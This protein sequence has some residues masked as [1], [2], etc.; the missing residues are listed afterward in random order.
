MKKRHLFAAAA[1]LALVSGSMVGCSPSGGGNAGGSASITTLTVASTTAPNSLDPA[2]S[3]SGTPVRW[4]VDP[5]Y[6]SVLSLDGT[7]KVVEGLA[8]TWEYV[9]SDNKTFKFHLR[10]GLK[11]ADGTPLGA[12]EAIASFKYFLSTGAGPTKALFAGWEF[13]ATDKNTVTI[14]TPNPVPVIPLLLTPDYLFGDIISPAGLADPSKLAAASFGAG[15][16]VMDS[17]QTVAGDHYTYVRNEN[18]HSPDS[19]KFDKIVA[20]VIPNL[21]QQVQALKT[22]QVQVIQGDSTV[23]QTIS[24]TGIDLLKRPSVWTGLYMFDREGT[25]VPALKDLR[26]RQAVNLALNRDE[27]VKAVYGEYATPTSQPA[28]PG[29]SEYGFSEDLDDSFGYDV[30]RAKKLL[31]E[32]GYANGFNMPVFYETYNP[33]EAKLAQVLADQLSKVGITLELK[34]DQN[35]SAWVTDLFSKKYAGT[36]FLGA[37]A[38]YQNVQW[39]LTK[40]ALNPFGVTVPEIEEAYAKL[41]ATTNPEE[42]KAAAVDVTKSIINN[43]PAAVVARVDALYGVDSAKVSGVNFLGDTAEL[44]SIV[45]WAPTK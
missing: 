8:D 11:F 30:E 2:Q 38:A 19:V 13:E 10:D 32:A 36:V 21:T 29:S 3:A 40:G 31:S 41:S 44:S 18:Y 5:S 26:V 6:A 1:A 17:T 12:A 20:K 22:G 23:A 28:I 25:I 4:F 39:F 37:G 35:F 42:Q 45:N 16:Y 7:G 33:A 43:A 34:G 14:R 24:G 27:I 9:G 15:P